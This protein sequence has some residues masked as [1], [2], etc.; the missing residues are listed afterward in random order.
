M[1][2]QITLWR[3][4]AMVLAP[5][6]LATLTRKV[7]AWP[8]AQKPALIA[9]CLLGAALT[10]P[11][12][13]C[14]EVTCA[15]A[16]TVNCNDHWSFDP[17]TVLDRCCSNFV[18]IP[19]GVVSS[20]T[21]PQYL[22]QSWQIND[23]CHFSNRCSQTV[24]VVN[25]N[26]PVFQA[27]NI[28][29]ASCATTQVFF[30]PSASEGCC[31]NLPVTCCPPSGSTFPLG[32]TFVT[33]T[34][35]DCCQNAY[36]TSFYV[37][38]SQNYIQL[39]PADKY[40]ACGDTSWT[41]DPP[42][43]YDPCCPGSYTFTPQPPVTNGIGCPLTITEVWGATDMC[44][45]SNYCTETIYLTN[46]PVACCV[47]TNG[48]KYL[49]SPDFNDGLGTLVEAGAAYI[50]ANR[51][52]CSNSGPIAD[53][54]LWGGWDYDQADPGGVFTLAIWSDGSNGTPNQVLWTQT[55]NP[56]DYQSC[57]ST[58]TVTPYDYPTY[59]SVGSYGYGTDINY[60]CFYPSN[61]F[62]QTGTA[63]APT[64]YWL[65]VSEQPGPGFSLPFGWMTST[66]TAHNR[67]RWHRRP[68]GLAVR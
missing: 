29:V 54:H 42:T 67:F 53:I 40:V 4:F 10:A 6:R 43:V 7:L 58:N 17:P 16:K 63:A 15:P 50:L 66:G 56:G 44:G 9:V 8:V 57:V 60:L 45:N 1:N 2:T 39:N 21:C 37:Y 27:P 64:N 34:R 30:S 26:Q 13:Q 62:V 31:G 14:L 65:S 32:V 55:F 22:T 61:A 48:V 46:A 24:T 59:G 25:T 18:I 35:T 68:G 33:C 36:S 41:F 52:S 38:V 3:P 49:Q 11:A 12:Q 47:E 5:A 23:I 19:L 28:T 20:G 51:F